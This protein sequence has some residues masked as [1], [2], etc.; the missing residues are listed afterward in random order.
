MQCS[1]IIFAY[2]MNCNSINCHYNYITHCCFK[3]GHWAI[4]K[5][6]WIQKLNEETYRA[7]VKDRGLGGN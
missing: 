3:G 2:K 5:E 7:T 4:W 6:G 1:L